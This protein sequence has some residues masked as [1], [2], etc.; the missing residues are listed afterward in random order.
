MNEL[1]ARGLISRPGRYSS[2]GRLQA[3]RDGTVREDSEC[4]I[5]LNDES[6]EIS[7]T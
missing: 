4:E 7:N 5:Y 3:C 1:V 6:L 2:S